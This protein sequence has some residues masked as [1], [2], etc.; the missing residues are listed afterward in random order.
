MVLHDRERIAAA[1][2][3]CIAK[4]VELVDALV[5]RM[6]SRVSWKRPRAG[7]TALLKFHDAGADAISDALFRERSTLLLPSTVFDFGD[8][9]ARLGLGRAAFSTA[10]GEIEAQLRT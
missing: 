3:A 7:S 1:N 8:A 2:R 4:N 10:L 9:H 6:P 5:A